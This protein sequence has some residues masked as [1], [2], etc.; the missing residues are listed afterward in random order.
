[1]TRAKQAAAR[2]MLKSLY[3]SSGKHSMARSLISVIII[4]IVLSACGTKGLLYLPEREYPLPAEK[5]ADNP[6]NPK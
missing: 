2:F 4:S 6:A 1:L 5:P 3:Q